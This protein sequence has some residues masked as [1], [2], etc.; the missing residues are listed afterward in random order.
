MVDVSRVG[1]EKRRKGLQSGEVR[2]HGWE[3][4]VAPAAVG[5]V[6]GQSARP[7][8]VSS[9]GE[10]SFRGAVRVVMRALA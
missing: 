2:D 6:P 8:C 7:G 10:C 4:G 5:R 3:R 1:Q 9:T